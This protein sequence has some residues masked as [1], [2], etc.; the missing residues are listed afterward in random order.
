MKKY[1]FDTRAVRKGLVSVAALLAATSIATASESVSV[2]GFVQLNTVWED[3][4]AST[5]ARNW[6]FVAPSGNDKGG[7]RTLLNV[8][9][10]RFG[11]NLNGPQ[12]EGAPELSGRFETDFNNSNGRNSNGFDGFRIRQAFGQVKFSDLGLTLLFGQ[13]G[14]VF[15]PRDPAIL[16]EGTF[17]Y[18]GNIGTRR[19]QIRITQVIGPIEAAV[20]ALDD[21]GATVPEVPAVQGRVGAKIPA[22]WAGEK[23]NLELGVSGHFAK[24][25][26]TDTTENQPY[27]KLPKSWSINA[28]LSLP[29]ISILSLSG[30]FFYGQNLRNYS[31]GSI[32]LTRTA[33]ITEIDGI[34]SVGGWANLGVK[35]PAN[36]TFNGGGGLESIS[37][38]DKLKP[39]R[40]S[41]NSGIYT[42]LRYNFTPS[43]FLGVE[44]FRIDTDYTNAADDA[45]TPSGAI[46]RVELAFQYAFK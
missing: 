30:E 18:V 9:H 23:Q 13:T 22:G 45:K 44:Y 14:E 1:F 15:S 37:N 12:A 28:D 4:V 34:K 24:E 33:T 7:S 38:D 39:G 41:S 16:S 40:P 20:A 19:P 35:L 43:A 46:N 32:G 6:S 21:R 3:G 27:V 10:S 8:N 29:V 5:T 42:N 2:Y 11:L 17:N 25:K 26:N 36:L 31:N